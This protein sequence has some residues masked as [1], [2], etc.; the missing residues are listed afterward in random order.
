MIPL[1]V[2]AVAYIEAFGGAL[3][4]P[5]NSTAR[6]SSEHFSVK[7]YNQKSGVALALIN[8]D[9]EKCDLINNIVD[10]KVLYDAEV[11]IDRHPYKW[12][13]Q[14]IYFYKMMFDKNDPLGSVFII[15]DCTIFLEILDGSLYETWK[16]EILRFNLNKQK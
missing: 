1:N 2:C 7:I 14:E 4:L 12:N 10:G 13:G 3:P 15:T 9:E 11:K 8:H 16:S 5:E 6:Y